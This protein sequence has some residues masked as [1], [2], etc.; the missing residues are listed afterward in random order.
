MDLK[1]CSECKHEI[2][3]NALE[4]ILWDRRNWHWVCLEK[5]KGRITCQ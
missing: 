3:P 4:P 5:S 2:I 1:V